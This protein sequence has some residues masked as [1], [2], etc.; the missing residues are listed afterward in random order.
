MKVGVIGYGYWGPKVARALSRV[1][2]AEQVVIC[3]PDPEA[4]AQAAC[5]HPLSLLASDYRA[6]LEDP[7]LGAVHV[8]TPTCSHYSV[9]REALLAGKHVLVEKPLA[10]TMAE[11]L[12]LAEEARSRG[13]VLMAGHVYLYNAPLSTLRDLLLDGRL[14]EPRYLYSQRTSL[15]P[16][17]REDVSVVWDYLIHDAYLLP[18]LL[19]RRP[20]TVSAHGGSYL[21]PGLP[22]VVFARLDFGDGVFAGC[23]ASWYDPLKVR[24]LTVVGSEKMAVF[25]ELSE[26]GRL[27]VMNRGYRPE[28]GRDAWGNTNLRLYDDGEHAVAVP[29]EEPL[30][31]Q[32]RAFIEA[33]RRGEPPSGHLEAALDSLAVLEAVDRSLEEG[34]RFVPV[35]YLLPCLSHC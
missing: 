31:A 10:A 16:R 15:G 18:H 14:G 25:N 13:L 24:R 29:E 30:V 7:S 4:R 12:A 35:E 22:D 21:R 8:C 5:T 20:E 27:L 23:H 3:E 9:A 1:L 28:P 2:A 34:G 17:V 11:G 6:L 32:A 26:D 19:G 33:A